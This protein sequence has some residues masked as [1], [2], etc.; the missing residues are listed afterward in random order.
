[1]S[2]FFVFSNLQDWKS[3]DFPADA[4]MSI[5]IADHVAL[6]TGQLLITAQ[7][8]TD[9]EIDYAVDGLIAELENVRRAAKTRINSDNSRVRNDV[10]KRL[11]ERDQ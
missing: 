8:A 3:G 4:F 11:E 1:M 5:G 10:T 6:P 9:V 2:R 7:L